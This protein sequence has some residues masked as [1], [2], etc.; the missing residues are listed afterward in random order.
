MATR[1]HNDFLD[2]E[3][4]EDDGSQGYNSEAENLR[5][6]GRSPKRRKVERDASDDEDAE[7]SDEETKEENKSK[8][9]ESENKET[10]KYRSVTDL[11]GVSKPLTKKNLVATAAAIKRSGVVYLS[12]IPPFMKPTKLRSL[13]EPYGAINRIFLTPEDPA[14]H[15]RRVRN[16]GN[17]KR[18]F[19]DGWVEFVNKA[20]AK[21]AC[22]LLNARTI[23]GKKGTYYHDD[24]WNL[25]YLKGFKWNNLTEQI[26]AENAER[27]SR[28]RAEISKTTKENKEFVQNVERAKM[29]EGMEAKKAAK[30]RKETEEGGSETIQ[31]EAKRGGERARHFKQTLVASKRR[32]EDQPDQVKRVLSKIF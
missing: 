30:R 14:S 15:T 25:L 9:R 19:V 26:A 18:S 32:P 11:P 3:E 10:T 22:E 21:Q 6:G 16:G 31:K 28:M 12:R 1:K 27:A 17:K 23:G 7:F 5:K 20:D 13:L 4:S 24:V 8:H 29:L 2:V